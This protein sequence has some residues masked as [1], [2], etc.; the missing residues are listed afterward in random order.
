[1]KL[2][3]ALM[4][5]SDL[6]RRLAQLN[7][8][9]EQNAQYQ[10]GEVPVEDPA[11]LLAEYRRSAQTLMDLIVAINRAN[12]RATLA[13]GTAMVAALAERDRLQ[14]EHSMLIKLADAATPDQSHYSRS[15]IK[16]LPAISVKDIRREADRVAKRCRELD[17]QIQEANWQCI[18]ER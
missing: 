8:R 18:L 9:L 14:A 17:V 3:Q 12:H 2:A 15:E 7:Q 11:D 4:E 6:Q 13:D 1:M 10:E 16:M 5:R